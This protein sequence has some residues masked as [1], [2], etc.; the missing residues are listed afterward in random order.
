[1]KLECNLFVDGIFEG[2][3]HSSKE[4]TVGKNGKI[5][6]EIYAKHLI[7]Q[8]EIKGNISVDIVEI[9]SS[10]KVS[11]TVESQELI[12]E[13]K[14]LFEGNSIIKGSSTTISK[15]MQLDKKQAS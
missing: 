2:T 10:G 13:P 8:G 9:K 3:I 1:M 15:P 5:M 11:G 7:V 14:G 12:I 6:G 4:I